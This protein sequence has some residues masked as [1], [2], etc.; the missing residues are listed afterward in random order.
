MSNPSIDLTIEGHVAI[1]T[2]NN[3][4][5][6]TWTEDT[7][8]ALKNT[9]YELNDNKNIYSLVLTGEGEKFFSAGADLNMFA[10]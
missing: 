7:L 6:N 4:P 2:M 3:P 9:V 5:A 10:E 8:T 1:L